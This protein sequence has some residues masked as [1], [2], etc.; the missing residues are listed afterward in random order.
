MSR[1]KVRE[2]Y[3]ASW[4]PDGSLGFSLT[5]AQLGEDGEVST[6]L[7]QVGGV[8]TFALEDAGSQTA[9]TLT[10]ERRALADLTWDSE[11]TSQEGPVVL[12]N[13][14]FPESPTGGVMIFRTPPVRVAQHH[15]H[16][17]KMREIITRAAE[18]TLISHFEKDV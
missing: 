8:A 4:R 18:L 17:A 3:V 7:G 14:F 5:F 1:V 13:R 9:I 2:E 12:V 16:H 11:T 15:H 10:P 6:L